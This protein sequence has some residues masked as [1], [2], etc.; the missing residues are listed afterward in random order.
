MLPVI[1]FIVRRYI[2][3]KQQFRFI[4]F[5]I[6]LAFIGITLGV[7]ALIIV[8]SIFN[9][10]RM[11]IQQQLLRFDPHIQVT[12]SPAFPVD[13]LEY[14]RTQLRALPSIRSV[15]PVVSGKTL[16]V[17]GQHFQSITLIGI[18]PDS[19]TLHTLDSTLI[20]G[21]VNLTPFPNNGLLIG[22]SLAN[23]LSLLPKDSVQ[24]LT[25]SDFAELLLPFP[26]Y[27]MLA[28]QI[29]GVFRA[30]DQR[31]DAAAAF[32]H[33]S[34]A[35]HIL[36]PAQRQAHLWIRSSTPEHLE[37]LKAAIAVRLPKTVRLQ[38]WRELNRSLYNVMQLE[39]TVAFGVI[40]LI[41]I[42]AI[43]SILASLFM[44]FQIKK[45]EIAILKAVGASSRQISNIF[46]L[47]SLFIG[48][49]ATLL[50][51][52]LGVA[53]VLS[54]QRWGWI[55]L[56]PHRYIVSALPMQFAWTDIFLIAVFTIALTLLA[57]TF[58]A[59][60]AATLRSV[61]G[62]LSEERLS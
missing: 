55:S 4:S 14:Y 46:L 36:P 38:E 9:G 54:Q 22:V 52:L 57:G 53:V 10:F 15:I 1:P 39:R 21:T 61:Y 51:S 60:R 8:L 45:P 50:G 59:Y 17:S 62:L 35:L 11:L 20:A 40:S 6:R 48:A 42:V 3:S 43:F 19:L 34:S 28:F 23:T 56:D 37:A 32:T 29:R 25:I 44:L 18:Q 31:Y 2:W 58:P 47:L 13:S 30:Q 24:A 5:L 41:L 49:G 7:M 27:R 16:L 26:T 12:F 33:L